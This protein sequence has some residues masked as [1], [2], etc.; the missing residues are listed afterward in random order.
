[1][2]LSVKGIVGLFERRGGELYGAEAVSQL[3]HALQCA[4]LAEAAGSGPDLV[5]AAL[6]HD[7]GHLVRDP[8]DD[9]AAEGSDDAHQ[10]LA[11][12]FLRAVFP[13]AVLVPIRLHVDAKRYLCATEPD[14]WETLSFA[15]KR[16]LERQGGPYTVDEAAKFI[17]KAHARDAVKLRRWDDAAKVPGRPTP[18]L[19]HFARVLEICQSSL[20]TQ[21]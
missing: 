8:G 16:S 9:P 21:T 14:Y 17:A 4:A 18:G 12:P 7:L 10:Y 20:I 19:A 1:V 3:D 15:S 11:L 2:S 5:A 6:M 13:L